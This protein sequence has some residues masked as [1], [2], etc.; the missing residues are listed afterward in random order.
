LVLV[1]LDAPLEGAADAV[2]DAEVEE[3]LALP[4]ATVAGLAT[5]P[6]LASGS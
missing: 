6:V 5:A 1:A 4:V 3:E 2:D